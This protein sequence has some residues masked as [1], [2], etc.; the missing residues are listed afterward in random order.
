M[1]KSRLQK[2]LAV[3]SP[4]G[5][6]VD[7]S[8]FDKAVEDLKSGLKE[9]IQAKTL[10]DVNTQLDLLR[11]RMDLGPLQEALEGTETS[12]DAKIKDITDKLETELTSFK[13]TGASD[14]KVS[15]EQLVSMAAT[16]TDLTDR[17]GGL[18]SQKDTDVKDLRTRLDSLPALFKRIDIALGDVKKEAATYRADDSKADQVALTALTDEIEKLRKELT[19]RINNIPRGGNANRNIAVGGNVGVLSKYTDINIKAG[20]N[21]TITYTNNETTKYLDL[22][23]A[24]TGGGGGTIRSINSIS[25]DTTAGSTA[26]TDYVYLVSGTTT[27]TLPTAVGNTNLYTVKNVGTGVVTINT[28]GG[29]SIDADTTVT[30]PVQYTSVDLISGGA[31]WNVT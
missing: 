7:F 8:A 29:Q 21:V 14:K 3:L 23:I 18:Q 26:G 6:E 24:A 22:T 16:I 31:N 12:L 15:G 27:L 19:N 2:I 25:S 5:T 11:K 20:A 10:D 13:D 4:D 9:K 28:T 30:M 1:P 17:L